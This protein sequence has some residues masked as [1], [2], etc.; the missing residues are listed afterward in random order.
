MVGR[1]MV[2]SPKVSAGDCEQWLMTYGFV[3]PAVRLVDATD[4]PDACVTKVEKSVSNNALND[5]I[6]LG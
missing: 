2:I 4:W 5:N 6:L 3:A 1:E